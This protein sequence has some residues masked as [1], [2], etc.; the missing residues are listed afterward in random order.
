MKSTTFIIL[1]DGGE[2]NLSILMTELEWARECKWTKSLW[3]P[4]PALIEINGSSSRP[5]FGQK[6][7]N[8]YFEIKEDASTH[9]HCDLC[10]VEII[11][12]E[13]FYVSS[14]NNICENCH[15][16]FIISTDINDV[17]KKMKKVER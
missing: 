11:K 9:D 5:Y 13:I 1:P 8:T 17:I 14:N 15:Q 4:K 10:T 12:D 16:N 6:F 3:K 7:D 2:L